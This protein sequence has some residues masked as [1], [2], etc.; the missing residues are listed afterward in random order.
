MDHLVF[1]KLLARE[2]RLAEA[3]IA[4]QRR[5]RS[6]LRSFGAASPPPPH[7]KSL[8]DLQIKALKRRAAAVDDPLGA[9]S[10]Q[11]KLE[12]IFV[13]ASFYE[14]RRFLATGDPA[15]A[16]AILRIADE[17]K[18]DRPSVCLG[19]ARAQAQL[20]ARAEAIQ[21]LACA[22]E[23][24]VTRTALEADPALEPLRAEPGYR[25][26]LDRSGN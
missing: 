10:A 23:A 21:A 2:R 25:D 13:Y 8:A 16:L 18:P 17:I 12:T 6:F 1:G 20:G 19:V 3:E 14:P 5:F 9:R 22:V 7:G 15:H 26:L 24:G 11:R 4:F